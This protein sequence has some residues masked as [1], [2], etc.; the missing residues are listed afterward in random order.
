M[1]FNFKP[2]DNFE[3][4]ISRT[5]Q[6]CGDGRP[7]GWDTFWDMFLGKDNA[8]DDGTNPD[9]E[10]GN[11]MAGFDMRWTNRWFET[12]VSIYAQAIGEDEAGGFPSRYL[13]QAGIEGSGITRDQVSYRWFA[14]WAGTTCDA[15]K[16][17]PLWGCGYRQAIYESGYTYY[18]RII[19]HGLDNDAR[20]LS[21]GVVVVTSTG[22]AWQVLGRVGE[23]NRVGSDP[24]HSVSV[25]P[26]DMASIDIQHTRDTKFGRFDVG[27][28]FERRED[29]A[30]GDNTRD[31]R[32]FLRWQHGWGG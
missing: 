26:A 3:F 15:I 23:L 28:G 9:N 27:L 2:T 1:R 32:G 22:N 6:W 5:A 18:G 10:P 21:A 20:V 8:G 16:S 11:Q 12:P 4:G 29:V 17:D 19:G 24:D 13:V 14:E 25:D 7:C 31:T 30:T